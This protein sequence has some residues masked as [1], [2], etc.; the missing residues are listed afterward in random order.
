MMTEFQVAANLFTSDEREAALLAQ[1]LQ[2]RATEPK[3]VPEPT[4]AAAEEPFN[5]EIKQGQIR[6][7]RAQDVENPY[8]IPYVVVL[9]EWDPDVWLIAPFSPYSVPVTPYEMSTGEK[10]MG[11][12][13]LQCWNSRTIPGILLEKSYIAGELPAKVV[14]WGQALFR[15]SL[16]R[17]SLPAD[18]NAERGF[19][20]RH[21]ADPRRRYQ[22]ESV[23]Q[24]EPLSSAA[25]LGWL[26]TRESLKTKGFESIGE[27]TPMHNWWA[28]YEK[29]QVALAAGD[30][31]PKL[32]VYPFGKG[33]LHVASS[34]EE[35][36]I[37][38]TFF[39]KD[40]S[41]EHRYDGCGLVA[42]TST[43]VGVIRNGV[44]RVPWS[45]HGQAFSVIDPDGKSL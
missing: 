5:P 22:D 11:L 19:P 40:G 29:Q 23:E 6:I 28:A 10:A 24:F 1:F 30:D 37:I 31:E 26:P 21:A 4:P 33:S 45:L 35:K 25:R 8:H 43:F 39:K 18:F 34:A 44:I 7:L 14:E 13:V 27:S 12:E 36:R 2:E 9:E 16:T 15:Y 41:V 32:E 38:L 3:V 20:I 17:K 42:G